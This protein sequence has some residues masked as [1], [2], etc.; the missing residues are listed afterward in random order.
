MSSHF[1]IHFARSGM[2][3]NP[4][5]VLENETRKCIGMVKKLSSKEKSSFPSR[6]FDEAEEAEKYIDDGLEIV[7]NDQKNL[8]RNVFFMQSVVHY[9][10]RN[11]EFALELC[12]KYYDGRDDLDNCIAT[13]AIEM[14]KGEI[15]AAQGRYDQAYESFEKY[16]NS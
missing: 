10:N 2:L 13:I 11:P 15:Y 16:L 8:Y 9:Q 7:K 6:F 12:E 3:T 1:L 14:M 4:S 5:G